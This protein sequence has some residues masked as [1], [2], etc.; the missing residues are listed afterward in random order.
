M[1]GTDFSRMATHIRYRTSHICT[2]RPSILDEC[3][4]ITILLFAWSTYIFIFVTRH[5]GHVDILLKAKAGLNNDTGDDIH[6]V[7]HTPLEIATQQYRLECVVMHERSLF[8][9]NNEC[10]SGF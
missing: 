5:A 4:A 1:A 3:A 7:A 6:E 8:I 2:L 9:S 10:R